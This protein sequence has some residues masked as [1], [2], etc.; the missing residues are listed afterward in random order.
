VGDGAG[1]LGVGNLIHG[2]TDSQG[3]P[4]V[5][6]KLL[7][8]TSLSSLD[9]IPKKQL[10]E[11]V[12]IRRAVEKL[13]DQSLVPGA[14]GGSADVTGSVLSAGST[15]EKLVTF[16][17]DING[18]TGNRSSGLLGTVGNFVRG[19]TTPLGGD[20][21]GTLFGPSTF[22]VSTGDGTA[23]VGSVTKAQRAGAAVGAAGAVVGGALGIRAGIQEG[24]AK[25]GLNALASGAGAAAA[26][27]APIPVAAAVAGGVA[28]LAGLVSS[29]LPDPRTVKDT[30][31][32]DYIKNNRIT[33]QAP[34]VR[35]LGTT[36]RELD[37]NYRGEL[38]ASAPVINLHINA[39]DAKSLLDRRNDLTDAVRLAFN[40]GHA[41]K[42]DV[43]FAAAT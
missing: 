31:L 29:L 5:I 16:G 32:N 4:T 23:T 39:L 2:Q 43:R 9:Q 3:N 13:A 36:G 28:V 20:A 42:D 10:D 25:G 40:D 1:K 12:K 34:I 24:G 27:L 33:D 17:S 15:A 41:L 6:G 30:M 18:L 19:V 11:A 38:R 22:S 14:P 7:A 26:L 37:Y 8:G 21:L 35:T